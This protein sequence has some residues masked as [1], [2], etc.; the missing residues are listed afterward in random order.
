MRK[1][2]HIKAFLLTIKFSGIASLQAILAD[3]LL[4]SPLHSLECK[5]SKQ[6]IFT[7]SL[8]QCEDFMVVSNAHIMGI[9][10]S[11]D[12]CALYHMLL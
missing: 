11:I 5:I 7:F 3:I 6:K 12:V 4:K 9:W 10:T 2:Y 8:W 1:V